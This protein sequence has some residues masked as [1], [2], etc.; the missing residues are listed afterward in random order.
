MLKKGVR[1]KLTIHSFGRPGMQVFP[2]SVMWL[3]G[4]SFS[5]VPAKQEFLQSIGLNVKKSLEELFGSDFIHI[6]KNFLLGA[7][8]GSIFDVVGIFSLDFGRRHAL[9]NLTGL[10]HHFGITQPPPAR[11]PTDY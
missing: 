5:V 10:T 9:G 8:D 6:M 11:R 2:G 4:C 1:A 3:E 7:E